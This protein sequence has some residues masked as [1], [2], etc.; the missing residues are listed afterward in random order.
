MHQ[1]DQ[2]NLLIRAGNSPDP[3]VLVEVT[4]EQAGWD[5]IHFQARRL[6]A[7][8]TWSFETGENE[9]ALVV[10][11]GTAVEVESSRGCW[12]GH[13]AARKRL[14]RAALRAVPARPHRF[15]ASRPKRTANLPSPGSGS[16]TRRIPAPAWSRPPDIGI[17]IRGG[18]HATRQINSI[19][20]PGFPCA[21]LVVVEVYTPGGN[22]SS[23]PPHK[24]DVHKI[25]TGRA[26]PRSRPGRNLLLQDRPPRGVC[27]PARLHRPRVPAA[28]GR[29]SRRCRC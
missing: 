6:E 26:S 16:Q 14:R 18:D 22:W 21:R 17:E 9:L 4:P 20:P 7:S 28:P 11:G 13:W 1:Y 10:L 25:G 5:T 23:Y 3:E 19:L 2:R 15:H 24:H 12:D 27:L 8:E 29:S